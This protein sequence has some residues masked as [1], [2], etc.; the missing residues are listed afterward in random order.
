MRTCFI[1]RPAAFLAV[2]CALNGPLYGQQLVPLRIP[3]LQWLSSSIESHPAIVAAERRLQSEEMRVRAAAAVTNPALLFI[4]AE[5]M[6]PGALADANLTIG[7]EHTFTPPA[8]RR[9]GLAAASA[10]RDVA[11]ASRDALRLQLESRF[12]RSFLETVVHRRIGRRLAEE[13]TL[14][15]RAEATLN[16]RFSVGEARYIDVIRLRTERLRVQADVLAANADADRALLDLRTIRADVATVDIDSA[17]LPLPEL[18][19][20]ID[21]PITRSPAVRMNVAIQQR[22]RAALLATTSQK[23]RTLSGHLGIQRFA[24]EGGGSS[25]GPSI[26]AS[27]SL[28]FN[29]ATIR[30][31]IEAAQLDT[32]AAG[33]QADAVTASLRAALISAFT[34]IE[35]AARRLAGIDRQLL[36]AAREERQ[37][38]LVAYANGE[39]SLV[40]LIDFERSLSRAEVQLLQTYDA[41]I[42]AWDRANQLLAGESTKGGLQ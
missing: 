28:P 7:V 18:P 13:D 10:E 35:A 39:L 14:L 6:D 29:R 19:A 37:A 26:G 11:L 31:S 15:Q 3:E 40:E 22:T 9:A 5:E 41:A 24:R 1:V 32:A 20:D 21:R 36:A 23:I 25:I 38:A 8:L 2:V 17:R 4:S 12:T 27:V 16:A 33:S 34:Q 42:E 30:A